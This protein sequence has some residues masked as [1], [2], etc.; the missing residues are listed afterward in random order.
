MQKEKAPTR[1]RF[2]HLLNAPKYVKPTTSQRKL[3]PF[4]A[5]DGKAGLF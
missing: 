1:R 5:G 3:F 4:D 2:T